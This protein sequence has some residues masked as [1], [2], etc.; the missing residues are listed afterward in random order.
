MIQIDPKALRPLLV[1][2]GLLAALWLA[3]SFLTFPMLIQHQ[4]DLADLMGQRDTM[5]AQ[6][7]RAEEDLSLLDRMADDWRR[8]DQAGA[9]DQPDRI[10]LADRLDSRMAEIGIDGAAYQFLPIEEQRLQVGQVQVLR[11]LIPVEVTLTAADDLDLLSFLRLEVVA[12]GALLRVSRMT[13]RRGDDG[14]ED[15]LSDG[16]GPAAVARLDLRLSWVTLVPVE[17]EP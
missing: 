6:I 15:W 13:L 3:R 12:E 17:A 7:A 16:T 5:A 4:A 2:I 14:P 11:R 10:A 8:L 1:A 9:F